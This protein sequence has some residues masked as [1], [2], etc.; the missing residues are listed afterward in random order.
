MTNVKSIGLITLGKKSYIDTLEGVDTKG[1]KHYTFHIRLKG[2]SPAAIEGHVRTERLNNS[3]YDEFELYQRLFDGEAI[4]FNMKV[5]NKVRFQKS[6]DQ[7]F[8][9]FSGNFKRTVK[10]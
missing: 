1:N 6:K 10:F 8:Y 4:Q 5:N 9:T 2:I 3:N 7:E